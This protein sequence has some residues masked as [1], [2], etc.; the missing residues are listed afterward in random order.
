M[1]VTP[2]GPPP[3]SRGGEAL[4]T[5][6]QRPP[7]FRRGS[8]LLRARCT[9]LRG[10]TAPLR[11]AAAAAHTMPP[12]KQ[13][14]EGKGQ[15]KESAQVA[16]PTGPVVIDKSGFVLISIH[17]KPG[18]KVNCVTDVTTEAVGVAIAAPPSDGEANAELCR[19]LSKVLEIKKSEVNLDKGGKSR[20]KV[21]KISAA[22]SPEIVLEKLKSEAAK[23]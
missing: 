12:R 11:A 20:E 23:S 2:G 15:K 9:A 17:A 16:H 14:K 7:V 10:V 13:S 21:V 22:I 18:S 8:M 6:R 3:H 5:G 19:Y 4:R 1:A